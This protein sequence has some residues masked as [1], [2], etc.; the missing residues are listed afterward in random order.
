MLRFAQVCAVPGLAG[1]HRRLAA[2]HPGSVDLLVVSLADPS[3]EPLLAGLSAEYDRRYGAVDRVVAL[4]DATPEEFDPPTGAFVVLVDGDVTIAGGGLRHV[5]AD[6][7]E[8]KRM[9]TAPEH[10]RQG[11]ATTVLRTLERLGAQQG[12]VRVLL[13]TGP[14]QPEAIDF[15]ASRGYVRVPN[16]GRYDVAVAYAREL[17]ETPLGPGLHGEQAP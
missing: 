7:C 16:Y 10:R 6:T 11:H 4:A 14:A 15:Y 17:S 13:E 9:W 12:Y 3:V 2:C 1:R 8:V 5:D